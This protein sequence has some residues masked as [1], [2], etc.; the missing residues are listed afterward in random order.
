MKREP[1]VLLQPGDDEHSGGG[2][3]HDQIFSKLTF[4]L[5]LRPPAAPPRPLPREFSLWL[6]PRGAAPHAVRSRRHAHRGAHPGRGR[7]VGARRWTLPATACALASGDQACPSLPGHGGWPRGARELRQDSSLGSTRA[8][9]W[10]AGRLRPGRC[11]CC[12]L[13]PRCCCCDAEA[14]SAGQWGRPC[15]RRL[16]WAPSRTAATPGLEE[17][18]LFWPRAPRGVKPLRSPTGSRRRRRAATEATVGG[19]AHSAAPQ[20]ELAGRRRRTAVALE[21]AQQR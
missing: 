12:C 3:A 11:C 17:T 15:A 8:R 4:L 13:A 1:N 10:S 14:R 5:L 18:T 21:D 19:A 20:P 16:A 7:R 6:R 2:A 9:W